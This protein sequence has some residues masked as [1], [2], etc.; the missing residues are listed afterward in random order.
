VRGRVD[1]SWACALA[2]LLAGAC[3]AAQT[4]APREPVDTRV[5]AFDAVFARIVGPESLD[6]TTEAYDA[7]LERLRGLLPPGDAVREAR[8]HAVY[9]GSSRWKN[10]AQGLAYSE[11]ARRMAR[12][13]RDVGSEARALLCRAGYTMQTSGSR[14]GLPDVDRAIALLEKGREPQLL[15]EALETRGDIQS[16]LGEQA[17]AMIDFQRA[18]A[19]Y[20]EAGIAHEV[21]ALMQSIA[22]AYRRMGDVEQAHRHF[23]GAL[24]RMRD[25]GNGEAVATNLI[26]LGFLHVESGAPDKA[27][28]AFQEAEQVAMQHR[29]AYSANAA[30]LGVAEAQIGLG[31][32]Q[33]ALESLALARKGFLAEQDSSSDDMLLLLS[34]QAM[35]RKGNHAG[36]MAHYQ[37]AL[38]LILR[39]GND[40]YLAMLY[41]AQAASREALGQATEALA[42]YKR[43]TELQ[44]KLHGKARLEQSRML[45][46]EYRIRQ[47]EFE[48]RRL[49][50][51]ADLRGQQ[52]ASLERMRRWQWLALALGGLLVA[53]LSSLAWRQWRRSRGLRVL[54]M[55]DAMT[56]AAS[57]IGI[58]D[59]AL[60]ALALAAQ[61][62]AP[63][64]VLMLDLDHFKSINDRHGH[65]AGDRVLAAVVAAWQRQLRVGDVLGRIGGEEFLVLCPG[66]ALDAAL[67]VAERLREATAALRIPEIDPAL[68]VTV[69]IGVAQAGH[70]ETRD[71]LFERV[72]A[73]LYRA[74]QRGRDR[75]DT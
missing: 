65:L 9:C 39:N 47:R 51:D 75:V 58:E 19:A 36:A 67:Q 16:L 41:K 21:E 66:T 62:G 13:A 14:R 5:R 27:L 10:A 69:S 68:Q 46:Y 7:D 49:R 56:G 45:E 26:Q 22:V 11:Q 63:L 17:R 40:R 24:A 4:P 54:A 37:A 72:D 64:S 25:R 50:Q 35:A 73:A 34:G 59:Q 15:A 8:L 53:L 32:P 52:L 23:T 70:A 60:R 33:A 48:N 57:R 18:R 2:L 74:K 3:A 44:L 31:Q 1:K 20:R 55:T 6:A 29:I 30:R 71:S 12:D 42:D 38:P 61:A 28:A 43:Y